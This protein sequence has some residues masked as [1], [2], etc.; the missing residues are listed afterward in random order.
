MMRFSNSFRS[1][2]SAGPAPIFLFIIFLSALGILNG[3]S[4]LSNG[5]KWGQDATWNP[6]WG[7]IKNSTVNAVLSPETWGP[8]AAALVL[9]IDDMDERI[10][11]WVSDKTPVFGSQNNAEKWS[12]YLRNTSGATY[13]LTTLITPSGEDPI[14]WSTAKLKGLAVGATAWGITAGTTE[15]LKDQTERTRPDKLDS[16]SFPSGHVSS[17]SSFTTL[18]RRNISCL[19]L[20]PAYEKFSNLGLYTISA[21]TAW[22]RVEAKKHYPSDALV[23]YAIGHFFSA[24]INDAFLGLDTKKGPFFTIEPS[25]HGMSVNL[26]WIY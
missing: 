7:R 17:A 6:G 18:S 3:C 13:V 14:E 21:G 10:S 11:D 23:G 5:R 9:Q 16:R 4:T 24:L 22:A 8:V 2:S 15:L 1:N 26:T 19:S 25:R 12:D 20:S